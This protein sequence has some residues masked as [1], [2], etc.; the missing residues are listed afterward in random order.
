MTKTVF[1]RIMPALMILASLQFS[2]SLTAQTA[3][4]TAAVSACSNATLKGTYNFVQSG[5]LVGA[6]GALT[7]VQVSGTEVFDGNGN[8]KGTATISTFTNGQPSTAGSPVA[9]TGTYTVS[10]N[11]SVTKVET[12]ANN[13]VYH[14]TQFIGPNNQLTTTEIDSG[15]ITVGSETPATAVTTASGT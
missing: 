13:N 7:Q 10:A 9:I 14:F 3:T 8:S 6:N 1:T 11:C 12:A 15:I 2:V 4:S 5:N